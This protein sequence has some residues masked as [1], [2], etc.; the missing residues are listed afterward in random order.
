M[1]NT[2]F[3][4]NNTSSISLPIGDIIKM[5]SSLLVPTTKLPSIP[6]ALILSGAQFRTG[7]SPRKIASRIIS[8][9]HEAGAPQGP[10]NDGSDNIEEKMEVIRVE[11]MIYALQN[12]AKVE[13]TVKPG[14]QVDGTFAGIGSGYIKGQTITNG[15]GQ[16]VIR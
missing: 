12:E 7:L 10:L 14:Q 15:K 13:V 16:A 11:E 8:R 1:A 3:N 2:E 5:F 6:P 4:P 9:Q